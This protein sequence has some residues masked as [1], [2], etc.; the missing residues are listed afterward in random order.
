MSNQSAGLPPSDFDFVLGSWNVAHSRLKRRLSGCTEWVEF[1]GTSSTSKIL[2]GMGNLEDNVLCL[3]EGEY[4]AAAVRSYNAETG[5][6]SIWW[7]DARNPGSLDTPVV[8]SFTDKTGIFYAEDILDGK[9]I[10]VRFTW[11]VPPDGSPRWEQAF[12]PDAGTTWETNWKM[13][14]TRTVPE[15]N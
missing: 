13:I 7:L 10:R 3:P 12:S 9:P 2:G 14:F 6:W 15:G 5:K 4:R 1:K 11:F 8:G